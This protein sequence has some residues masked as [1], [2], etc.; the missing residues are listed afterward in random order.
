MEQIVYLELDGEKILSCGSS[1]CTT[2][3]R[4]VIVD[5][6]HE[7]IDNVWGW[8]LIDDELVKKEGEAQNRLL[9]IVKEQKDEELNLACNRAILNGFDYTI[10]GISYHFS[11][12]IEA[13]F[14]FQGVQ[15]LLAN[16]TI[17]EI[18]WTVL[19]NETKE[20]ERITVNSQLISTLSM[21][22]LHHKN[23]N[24]SKYRDFLSVQLQNATTIEEVQEI[25]W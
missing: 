17:S 7:I 25:K 5:S 18:P 11:F 13:Q 8:Y 9:Q 16:G 19:N 3:Y 12:D 20:H 1:P 24:I 6:N 21:V 10:N 2:D 4:S 23:S 22:I 15:S 14:N